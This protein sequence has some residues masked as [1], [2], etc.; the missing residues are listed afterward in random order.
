MA[1]PKKPVVGTIAW[2]DLTVKNATRIRDFY[3]QV[4]GWKVSRVEMGGYSDFCMLAPATGETVAGICHARG[5]NAGLPA[6]WL[7]YVVVENVERSAANCRKL[8]G[9]VL[10]KPRAMAGGRFCVIRD[11]AGAVCALYRP[12]R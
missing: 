8:G 11:P 6:Q 1:R 3:A 10:V 7:N 5:S 4:V 12:P 2:R 9:R